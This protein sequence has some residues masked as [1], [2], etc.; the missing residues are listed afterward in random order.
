[1][2][3]EKTLSWFISDFINRTGKSIGWIVEKSGVSYDTVRRTLLNEV[4]PTYDKSW[5][6]MEAIGMAL[7]DINYICNKEY[8]R[9]YLCKKNNMDYQVNHV[10][11]EGYIKTTKTLL[12][13]GL[14]NKMNGTNK[15]EVAN[16]INNDSEPVLDT[17]YQAKAI[18]DINGRIR[19]CNTYSGGNIALSIVLKIS[20]LGIE[21]IDMKDK[22]RHGASTITGSYNEEG[23]K[24]IRRLEEMIK[25]TVNEID[26]DPSLRG[27]NVC[28][29][30]MS[31]I[32]VKDII[33]QD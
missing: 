24:K 29:F 14:S 28:F 8:G 16:Y 3:E 27:D 4:K 17:L 20:E 5:A 9:T 2:M 26:N 15:W 13:F 10:A 11:A 21:T 31:K 18:R 23:I 25:R 19:A 22:Y 7:E 6:I 33:K 1:M 32:E 12:A 30:G